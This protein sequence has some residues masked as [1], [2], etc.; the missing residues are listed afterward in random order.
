[1]SLYVCACGHLRLYHVLFF[2]TFH[3][4]KS[5]SCLIMVDVFRSVLDFGY[6]R[7]FRMRS[8]I[9]YFYSYFAEGRFGSPA[10]LSPGVS[11][12]FAKNSLKI[13]KKLMKDTLV[14]DVHAKNQRI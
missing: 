8:V 9:I 1:M 13:Q 4:N 3:C 14:R 11:S 10:H 7:I 12:K 2:L 5:L 6:G